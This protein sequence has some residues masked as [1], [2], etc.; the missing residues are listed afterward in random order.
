M[1]TC[2]DFIWISE[3]FRVLTR[4]FDVQNKKCIVRL[5]DSRPNSMMFGHR[6]IRRALKFVSEQELC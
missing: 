1:L 3:S 5:L 2:D 4:S 6:H